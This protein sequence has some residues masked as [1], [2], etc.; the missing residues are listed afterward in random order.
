MITLISIANGVDMIVMFMMAQLSKIERRDSVWLTQVMSSKRMQLVVWVDPYHWQ[1]CG[2]FIV[3]WI[4]MVTMNVV[5][6]VS[7]LRRRGCADEVSIVDCSGIADWLSLYSRW[8]IRVTNIH[9][10]TLSICLCCV[11]DHFTARRALGVWD[12]VSGDGNVWTCR[13]I[14]T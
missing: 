11:W 2:V 6:C 8:C 1:S 14:K 3:W 4:S 10:H 7:T 13:R 5:Y 9:Q 12:V